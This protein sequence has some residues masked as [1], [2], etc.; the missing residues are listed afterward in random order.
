MQI[1][2]FLSYSILPILFLI[3]LISS[4]SK[5]IPA[6]ETFTTGVTDSFSTILKIFPTMLAVVVAINLFKASGAMDVLVRLLSPILSL[7]KVPP[8]VVPLSFMRSISGGGSVA[9]LTD[10]LKTH[11]P[12]SLIGNIAST[13]MGSSDTTLYVIAMYTASIGITNTKKALLIG[14]ICD[15]I[16]FFVTIY[17]FV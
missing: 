11:G 6:Y 1:I 13:I 5:K 9:I 12:D 8:E 17:I 2:E 14:L 4:L 16:A 7:V 10:I 15:L 3:I